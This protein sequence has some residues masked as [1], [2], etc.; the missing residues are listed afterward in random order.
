[1]KYIIGVDVG[2]TK[3]SA[4]LVYGN[5]VPKLIKVPTEASLGAKHIINNII[6]VI[7]IFDNPKIHALG[8]AVAGEIDPS[9]GIVVSSPNM[10][11]DFKNI[12][13]A[14]ILKR[15]FKKDIFVEND[16]NCFT[17][18]EAVYGAGKKY[19]IVIGLT[20]GTGVGSGMAIQKKIYHGSTGR[21]T[22]FG[23]M[24]IAENGFP[25]GCG[26]LGHLEAYASGTGMIR[27]YQELS[28]E[29]KDTFFIE[30]MAIRKQRHAVRTFKIMS[31]A[32]G[33]G[34]ASL[35]NGLNPDIVILGG[36]LTRVKLLLSPISGFVKKE[37]VYHSLKKTKIKLS[38]L[39]DKAPIVGA[40]LLAHG[41]YR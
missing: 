26:H 11:K 4:G 29:K 31:H 37:I 14:R 20:L 34:I 38:Q 2:A 16:A 3:I 9:L 33:V 12:H 40:S 30:E 35:I 17:L 36:G 41:G 28:G 8:V 25:C 22:E 32:L 10:P 24:T 27:I 39:K 18:G 19:N 23:H 1:M 6:K 13:L 21:A 7:K 15:I 5:V